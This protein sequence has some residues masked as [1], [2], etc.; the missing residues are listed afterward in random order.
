M[1]KC[2]LSSR[3]SLHRTFAKRLQPGVS[4]VVVVEKL[5]DLG[6]NDASSPGMPS[7]ALVKEKEVKP[8]NVHVLRLS[9]AIEKDQKL[10]E[11][12]VEPQKQADVVVIASEAPMVDDSPTNSLQ[13]QPSPAELSDASDTSDTHL[14]TASPVSQN[15]TTKDPSDLLQARNVLKLNPT[16]QQFLS[17]L[18]QPKKKPNAKPSSVRNTW[19]RN[20]LAKKNKPRISAPVADSVPG[21]RQLLLQDCFKPS[22]VPCEEDFN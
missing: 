6:L 8:F 13:S 22:P 15:D 12:P 7:A 19:R 21:V 5:K 16:P 3:K 10:P 9:E 1:R 17:L 14:H 11:R 20:S 2:G 4:E 18:K